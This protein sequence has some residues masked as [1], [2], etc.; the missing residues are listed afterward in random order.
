MRN[1]SQYRKYAEDCD[2]LAQLTRDERYRTVLNDMAKTWR[3]LAHEA[4]RLQGAEQV[5]ESN[6]G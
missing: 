4:E 2:R 3:K 5:R 6:E 1:P